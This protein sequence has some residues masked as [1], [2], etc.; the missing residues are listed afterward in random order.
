MEP[1]ATGQSKLQ[2][3]YEF[4]RKLFKL[5]IG[6]GLAFWAI[7]IAAS[8]LPMMAEFRAALSISYTQVVLVEPLLAGMIISC[9]VSFLLL[10]FLIRIQQRIQ[11]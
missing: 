1:R 5:I 2:T 8:L 7:T 9:F 6:G 4:Y 10:R 3:S 11:F